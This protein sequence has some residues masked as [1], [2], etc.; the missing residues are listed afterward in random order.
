[1]RAGGTLLLVTAEVKLEDI[2]LSE[3][4]QTEEDTLAPQGWARWGQAAGAVA[5]IGIANKS[6]SWEVPRVGCGA[7]FIL[8]SSC[9][10][11]GLRCARQDTLIQ[12]GTACPGGLA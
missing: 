2:T 1:M 12:A 6:I 7:N 10:N 3:L 11:R 8:S 4:S 5:A 9:S